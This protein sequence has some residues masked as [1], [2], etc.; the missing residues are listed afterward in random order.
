MSY[1]DI[2]LYHAY[3]T[4]YRLTV[5][6]FDFE[7]LE[8]YVRLC[9]IF[10]GDINVKKYRLDIIIIA[11]ILVISLLLFL[12]VTYQNDTFATPSEVYIFVD[13]ALFGEYPLD[14]DNVIN[15]DTEFG[16]NTVVINNCKVKMSESDCDNFS[17]INM[18]EISMANESIIC[19]PHRLVI[20][21]KCDKE[22]IDAI[23]Y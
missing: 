23:A 20:E 22:N 18:G 21:L 13:G 16:H 17:C 6:D 5:K 7:L 9:Y 10:Y 4:I 19:I 2:L 8:T 15:I 11:F 14:V 1:K 3:S 12:L